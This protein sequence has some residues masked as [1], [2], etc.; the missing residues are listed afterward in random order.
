MKFKNYIKTLQVGKI[1]SKFQDQIRE[2]K[3]SKR[4]EKAK[5]AM[6]AKATSPNHVGQRAFFIYVCCHAPRSPFT[7]GACTIPGKY[8][9]LFYSLCGF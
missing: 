2:G 3:H 1:L 8:N 6:E 4:Q 9:F 5:L 7:L